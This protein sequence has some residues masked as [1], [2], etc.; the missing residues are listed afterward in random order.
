VHRVPPSRLVDRVEEV[1][2][3]V[4]GRSVIDLGFVD[5]GQMSAKS[6]RGTWL[7]EVVRA[8]SRSCVGVDADSSGVERARGLGFDV[9]AADVEDPE[10]V[11]ALGLAPAEVVLA[12]ELVEHLDHPGRFLEAVKSLVAPGGALVLTTPNAHALT[13]TLG[14][15]AGRELV[16]PDHVSWLS[17][18][19]LTT[20]LERQGWRLDELAY[21]RFPHVESGARAARLAF[22][23]YQQAARPLFRLRPNLADGLLVV[24][25]LA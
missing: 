2:R 15:L 8:E 6:G 17:W 22:N 4:R 1:R 10:A 7:H 3:L 24:A 21:Y 9:Q 5:E 23:A 14:A 18:R 25:R 11:A 13:N 12:G 16:N 19:T 20:L